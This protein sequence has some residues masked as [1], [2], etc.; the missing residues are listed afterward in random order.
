MNEVKHK[1]LVGD[2]L[3]AQIWNKRINIFTHNEYLVRCAVEMTMKK[4][5]FIPDFSN[6]NR[7]PLPHI[8]LDKTRDLKPTKVIYR[9]DK[10]CF[11][12]WYKAEHYSGG[13]HYIC[14]WFRLPYCMPEIWYR[15]KDTKYAAKIMAKTLGAKE[16]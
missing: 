3:S 11:Y 16:G 1:H 9:K 5:C 14:L 13:T 12:Y 10:V 2:I 15:I 8:I 4:Y 6:S 7:K